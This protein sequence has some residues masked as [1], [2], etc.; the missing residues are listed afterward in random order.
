MAVRMTLDYGECFRCKRLMP[1][2]KLMQIRFYTGHLHVGSFHHQL[3]CVG[4][5]E[6]ADEIFH[7][8]EFKDIENGARE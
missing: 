7:H 4:C 5:R 2:E 3:L 8:V 6:K 1:V